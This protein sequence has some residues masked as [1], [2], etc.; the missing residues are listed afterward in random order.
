QGFAFAFAVGEQALE[1]FSGHVPLFGVV[2]AL[3]VV[4]RALDLVYAHAQHAP[5]GVQCRQCASDVVERALNLLGGHAHDC[6]VHHG[7]ASSNS[8][9]QRSY[10]RAKRPPW[11]ILSSRVVD[12]R[13]T[14]WW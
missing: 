9:W 2:F 11:I 7:I 12:V 4:E 6:L 5:V 10:S 14:A 1:L 8:R 3:D 13:S